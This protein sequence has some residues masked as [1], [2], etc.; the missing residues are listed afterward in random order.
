[1]LHRAIQVADLT[2]P[3]G[4]RLEPLQGKRKG[5]FSIRVNDQFRICFAWSEGNVRNVEI[6]DYHPEGV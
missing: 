5:Q 2:S 6:V 3:P 4:N 1:M